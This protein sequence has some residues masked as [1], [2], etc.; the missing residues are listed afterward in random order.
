MERRNFIKGAGLITMGSSMSHFLH[1]FVEKNQRENMYALACIPTTADIAGPFYL[2]NTPTRE[3]IIPEN[4]PGIPLRIEGRVLNEDCFPIH[5]ASV[6]VWHC[7]TNAIYDMNSPDLWHRGTFF[8]EE[9]GSYSFNTIIP[10]RYLNGS[11]FR[12]AHL[13]FRITAVGH[14]SKITQLYFAEDPY[15]EADPWA[16]HPDAEHRILP[17]EE[18]GEGFK[19]N[20]D[21]VI[22]EIVS[23]SEI[24]QTDIPFVI[25]N[26]FKESLRI[27]CRS[28]VI[29]SDIEIFNANGGLVHR[30]YALNLDEYR[31]D[32][33][34]W[35]SGYY[36]CRIRCNKGIYVIPLVRS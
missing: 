8:A 9:D 27:N 2:P 26:P 3:T 12:P 23:T 19:I 31:V 14:S 25:E 7:D 13:H 24:E 35:A 16:S 32:T 15:I 22:R 36:F 10:G 11:Q 34:S 20:F 33:R 17:L 18:E 29:L 30:Q 4:D 21:F 1:A 6:E 28:G 5:N